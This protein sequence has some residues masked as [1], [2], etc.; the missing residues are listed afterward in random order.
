MGRE[1]VCR[2]GGGKEWSPE[3]RGQPALQRGGELAVEGP[4]GAKALRRQRLLFLGY[5]GG[6]WSLELLLPPG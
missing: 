1:R 2:Q 5:R 3:V 4:A 6:K